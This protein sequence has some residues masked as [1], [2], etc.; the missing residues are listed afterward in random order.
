MNPKYAITLTIALAT[1]AAFASERYE[2]EIHT[3]L[4]QKTFSREYEPS[5]KAFNQSVES[6]ARELRSQPAGGSAWIN[7]AD[8]PRTTT[9]VTNTVKGDIGGFGGSVSHQG[10]PSTQSADE[11]ALKQLEK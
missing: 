11:A 10:P 2:A 4:G 6:R 9:T 3:P 7:R 1:S 5:R 8:Q